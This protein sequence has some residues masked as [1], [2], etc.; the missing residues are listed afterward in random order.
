MEALNA[1]NIST[2]L[3]AHSV[4]TSSSSSSSSTTPST[5]SNSVANNSSS[6]SSS[7]SSIPMVPLNTSLHH[8]EEAYF[9]NIPRPEDVDM[10]PLPP[11]YSTTAATVASLPPLPPLPSVVNE[12]TTRQAVQ[13]W[14]IHR[15]IFR[16]L[17]RRPVFIISKSGHQKKKIKQP[18]V[19]LQP[20]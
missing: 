15:A 11:P 12:D 19:M 8:S 18:S 3:V 2:S 14:H 17:G 5:S 20:V 9:P 6:S 16:R 13:S 7:S 1:S 4:S 10:K